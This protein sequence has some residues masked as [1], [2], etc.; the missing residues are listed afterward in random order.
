[1]SLTEWRWTEVVRRLNDIESIEVL[2][3][4]SATAIYGSRGGNG[5][6][7]V[8]TKQG[9]EGKMKVSYD[10]YYGI[11]EVSKTIEMLD[12]YQYA[13]LA[14]DGHDN[15][16][17][18]VVPDGT[19]DDQNLVRPTGWQRT[20][21]ELFPYLAGVEGLTNTDW[22]DEIFRTASIQRHTVSFSGG[23]KKVNYF[24]SGT[25]FDQDGTI[26]H[27][28]FKRYGAR[29]NLTA[30]EGK[31]KF[32]LNFT[33]TFSQ[34]ARVNAYGPY[35]DEGVV[36]SALQISPT[37][38]VYNPDG[39]YNHLSNG[40]WRIGTDFQH[41]EVLNPVALADLID[42][43]VRR[44]NVL[45]NLFVEYEV[46]KNLKIKTSLAGVFNHYHND[47]YRPS[48]LPDRGAA[49]FLSP[50]NPDARSSST[51]YTNYLSETTLN[52]NQ[53]FD[54]HNLGFVGGFSAQKNYRNQHRVEATNFPND[55]VQTVNAGEVVDGT[56][57]ISEWSLLSYLGRV[58]YDYNGKYLFSAAM[59]TDGSSRFGRN[60]RW[61]YFPSA[62]AGWRI[63]AEEF[64]QPLDFIYDM[65]LRASYGVTGNF[66]IGNYDHIPRINEED[67]ILGGGQGSLANGIKLTNVP[68]DD[69]GWETTT[70]LDFGVDLSLFDGKIN[71]EADYYDARTSDLLLDVPVPL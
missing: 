7:I 66:Q 51:F 35:F 54:K 52:Y 56:S 20:P 44:T 12:A 2:K 68:N 43:E 61:G 18:D 62:S 39:T 63:S 32:G 23:G 17:M 69:L 48:T 10:G 14:K 19:P 71:L 38:S 36:G 49:N 8:T 59:R 24:L 16:Y 37:W 27:N 41:N 42:D 40:Y 50:S 9:A 34:E 29:L 30:T 4:A 70:M 45:S 58:Q 53:S 57:V 6:V 11:Q 67:Y 64:M 22:Q 28:N 55:L 21:P 33:P 3:D 60:N 31:F 47:Y 13:E 5:V 15:A 1:M 65:K 25:Y 26:I 46:L